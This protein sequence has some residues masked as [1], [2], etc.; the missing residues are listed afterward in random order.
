MRH[1]TLQALALS[2]PQRNGSTL[3]RSFREADLPRFAA[4][5]ADAVLAKYQ[6]WEPMSVESAK[7]FLLSTANA[8]HL[9]PGSWIQLAIAEADA[10]TL[11]GDVGLFLSADCAFASLGFTL[12]RPHHGQGHATRAVELAI[13]QALRVASVNEVRAMTDQQN[14]ASIA[15]LRRAQFTQVGAQE[16]VYKGK[17]CVELLFARPRAEAPSAI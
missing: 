16:A 11:I 9:K 14:H 6:G 1:H 10:D 2:L 13:A 12:A 15:V 8:T 7:A 4:Y 3:L 17:P 5:R